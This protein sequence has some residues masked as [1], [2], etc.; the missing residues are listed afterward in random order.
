MAT[1][2]LQEQEQ[3]DALKAW[4]NDSGRW[5][6]LMLALVVGGIVATQGWR[7]WQAKQANAAATL[8]AEVGKQ[9]A[10]KDPKRINDAAQAVLDK[11][12]SS[13]YAPRAQLL[14]AQVNIEA[15]DTARAKTQLQWVAEHASEE[16]L[17]SVARLKL[18]SVLLDEKNYTDALAQLD[19]KHPETFD[20]LYADLKGDV[21]LAQGK[22]VEARAA[23][24]LA[25]DKTDAKSTYRNLIQMKLDALGGAK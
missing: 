12:G 13:V 2:D 5:V 25:Y 9:F 7:S 24:K 22:P 17:R 14:A 11:Y 8:F 10:S 3:I 15:R 16:G 1:L 21:L 23:Y 18:A 4:W 6:L 20:G 19:A